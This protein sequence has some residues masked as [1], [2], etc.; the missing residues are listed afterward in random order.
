[1]CRYNEKSGQ[2]KDCRRSPVGRAWDALSECWGFGP[3]L[4]EMCFCI[5]FKP[6]PLMRP[7]VHHSQKLQLLSL[8]PPWPHC[9]LYSTYYKLLESQYDIWLLSYEINWGYLTFPP[10]IITALNASSDSLDS[11]LLDSCSVHQN[12]RGFSW[13]LIIFIAI[14]KA[15][16]KEWGACLLL[17]SWLAL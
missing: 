9:L 11:T 17:L 7:L 6:F 8:C 12:R 3:Y 10:A 13:S 14:H 1:M 4:L 16:P 2:G 15:V 5:H